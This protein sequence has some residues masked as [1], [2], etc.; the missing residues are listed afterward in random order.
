MERLG[1]LFWRGVTALALAAMISTAAAPVAL[2]GPI[3]R[4]TEPAHGQ[5][6]QGE[7]LINVA[8][9]TDSDRPITRLDLLIDD[10]LVRQYTLAVPR[11]E[12]AQSF[13]WEFTAA[14]G[15]QHSIGARAIDAAGEVG[16]AAISVTVA[17]ATTVGAGGVDRIPPVINIYYP[18]Q[19]AELS[20][21]VEIRAE[22]TDNVGVRYVFF[23]I[24]GKLH[25]MIM[26]SPPFVDL[27]DTTRVAD[28]THVLQAKA[29]DAAENAGTSAEVTVVV[30]NHDMTLAP[31]GALEPASGA[32]APAVGV[33]EPTVI[34]GQFG[35]VQDEQPTLMAAIGSEAQAARVGYVPAIGERPVLARTSAPRAGA[36]MERGEPSEPVGPQLATAVVA[37]RLTAPRTEPAPPPAEL[38]VPL[39]PGYAVLEPALQVW[40]EPAAGVSR[41]TAPVR[42]LVPDETLTVDP[43]QTGSL[44][45]RTLPEGEMGE[46][47]AVVA[48]APGQPAEA[49]AFGPLDDAT[50]TTRIAVLPERATRAAIPADGRVTRP[51]EVAI[52]PVATM[53]FEDVAVLFNSET[54]ELLTQ[55][56]VRDGI[57][58]PPLREIFEAS[59]GVLYWYPVEKRVRAVRPGTELAIQIGDPAVQVNE[60]TRELQVA[61]YIKQGRTMVP[62]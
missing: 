41:T 56:E 20:G 4:I 32:A 7:I 47:E 31:S 42:S 54:L 21:E 39:A 19:G 45:A 43:S 14:A 26:N 24:D 37:P 18:A 5:L 46:F 11:L 13:S 10:A 12:G 3:V 8:F 59:D 40:P 57:S 38:G 48:P 9:R 29:M 6:V 53:S 30:R 33:R 15:S 28:G 17:G 35:G 23:Y 22:G 1:S 55:P 51:G 25:K 50:G 36:L 34:E 27:W 62:L 61:P 2:A 52:A 44:I 60:D 49:L 58:I 16:S